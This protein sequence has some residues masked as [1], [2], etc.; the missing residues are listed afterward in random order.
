MPAS[1]I[2]PELTSHQ[3]AR[4][5][6]LFASGISSE[7]GAHQMPQSADPASIPSSS[8][9]EFRPVQD[10]LAP[11]WKLAD[12]K[13]IPPGFED[14]RTRFAGAWIEA[15][16]RDDKRKCSWSNVSAAVSLAAQKKAQEGK[17]RLER[18]SK[19]QFLLAAIQK[20][21]V[22]RT[23]FQKISYEGA[24]ARKGAEDDERS[25]WLHILAGI[26]QNTDSPMARLLRERSQG[27]CCFSAHQAMRFFGEGTAFPEQERLTDSAVCVLAKK[28]ILAPSG[29]F[30]E[31]GP[32]ISI[33]DLGSSR[34]CRLRSLSRSGQQNLQLVDF[35]PVLGNLE[36]L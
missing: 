30:L 17:A 7:L 3:M 36:V 15:A 1:G 23:R 34:G 8:S 33:G 5:Q 24:T 19:D 35:G 6:N 12:Q 16:A 27:T 2:S 32:E 11:C 18:H 9:I 26:V 14:A 4:V 28:E 25:R 21:S 20:P 10:S 31:A 22:F 13:V 29:R